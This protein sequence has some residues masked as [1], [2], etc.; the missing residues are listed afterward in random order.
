MT[1]ESTACGKD[2][3]QHVA[4]FAPYA[5]AGIDEIFIANIGPNY[6]EFFTLYGM[7]VLPRMRS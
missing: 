3:D 2:M 5:D 1:R 4:A 6:R 7:E